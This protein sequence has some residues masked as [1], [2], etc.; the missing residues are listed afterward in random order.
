M[1]QSLETQRL[2]QLARQR[3]KAVEAA[4][5]AAT[6]TEEFA[7]QTREK[8]RRSMEINKE[9]RD[10]QLKALQEKLKTHVSCHHGLSFH[11]L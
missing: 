4:S 10:A 1:L 3:E 5:K 2:E 7:K 11:E 9:N 8:L 6:E